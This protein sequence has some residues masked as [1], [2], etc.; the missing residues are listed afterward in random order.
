MMPAQATEFLQSMEAQTDQC[1]GAPGTGD[2]DI[3]ASCD[4]Y[5][6]FNACSD[7]GYDT[8]AG[9]LRAEDS[10]AQACQDVATYGSDG[11]G[12]PYESTDPTDHATS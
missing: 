10:T 6:I 12:D 9:A 4:V 2:R 11:D 7:L 3:G 1:N 8:I 5:S